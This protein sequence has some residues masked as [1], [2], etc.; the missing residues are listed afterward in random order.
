MLAE[1]IIRHRL[2]RQ[3]KSVRAALLASEATS[4][5]QR[6][7]IEEAFGCK[8]FEWYGHSERTILAG[9]CRHTDE[10]HCFPDYGLAELIDEDGEPITDADQPGE[11]VGTGLQNRALP[12]IRYRTGDRARWAAG[13]C[14]CKRQWQRIRD[15]QGR[16]NQEMLIGAEGERISLAALNMH[17]P[18][19]E[20]VIRY[21]YAQH[22]PGRAEL[23]LMTR[24][25][26]TR[27][28]LEGIRKAYACKT[29]GC[30]DLDIRV[31][32][33]IALTARGKYRMLEAGLEPEAQLELKRCA[34]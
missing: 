27:A 4:L 3:V 29:R 24:S 15:V 33:N 8:A 2:R 22:R 14:G 31:V 21:Q 13:P 12:L 26:F 9:Q 32:E 1:F 28:D 20:R 17:G 11:L 7:A 30:L 10:Y 34:S 23:R 18:L 25:D 5:D 16:W 19:F 6:R